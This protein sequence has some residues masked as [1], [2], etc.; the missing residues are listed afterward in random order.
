[1]AMLSGHRYK[2]LFF[3]N[4]SRDTSVAMLKRISA[5]DSALRTINHARNFG[6]VW[7]PIPATFRPTETM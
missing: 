6:H 5:A 2:H 7:S 4:S 3:D 1:M